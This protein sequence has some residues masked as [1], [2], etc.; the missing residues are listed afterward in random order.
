MFRYLKWEEIVSKG[1]IEF[2]KLTP[3]NYAAFFH[4][5][6]SFTGKNVDQV[7]TC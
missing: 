3:T 5:L 6:R 4:G 2:E 1:N 7:D